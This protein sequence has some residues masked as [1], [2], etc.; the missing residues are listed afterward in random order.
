[1]P[2]IFR[3]GAEI[4]RLRCPR[5]WRGTKESA[6][7]EAESTATHSPMLDP[8]WTCENGYAHALTLISRLEHQKARGGLA[9]RLLGQALHPA[10][11]RG[12]RYA[13]RRPPPSGRFGQLVPAPERRSEEHTSELP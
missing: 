9:K 2:T 1:M 13:S 12:R 3:G 7:Q 4:S 8:S 6:R 11:P 10:P 5:G